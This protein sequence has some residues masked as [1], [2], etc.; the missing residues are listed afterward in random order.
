LVVVVVVVVVV[1]Q[2]VTI[3]PKF[4]Q[5]A[6]ALYIAEQQAREELHL[7]QKLNQKLAKKYVPAAKVVVVVL[8]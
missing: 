7:K 5:Q 8:K 1:V 3:N 4:A 2:Q 6:Q